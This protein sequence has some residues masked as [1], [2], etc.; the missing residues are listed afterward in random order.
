MMTTTEAKADLLTTHCPRC[1]RLMVLRLSLD[2]DR[3]DAARLARL[4][5]CDRCQ[6][7]RRLHHEPRQSQDRFATLPYRDD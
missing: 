1:A 2:C 6:G 7:E 3:A 4:V 5:V